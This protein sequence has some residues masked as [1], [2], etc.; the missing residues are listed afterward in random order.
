MITIDNITK[1]YAFALL[2]IIYS[3]YKLK[4][5]AL[6]CSKEKVISNIRKRKVKKRQIMI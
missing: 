5:P 2:S 6:S 3:Y 1:S 4:R